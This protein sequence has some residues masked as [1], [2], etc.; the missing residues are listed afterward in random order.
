[1]NRSFILGLIVLALCA[2]STTQP[3]QPQNKDAHYYLQQG[4]IA[5]EKEH[6]PEAIEHW[7]KVRDSFTSPE[8]TALAELKIADA[9]FN[10]DQLIEAIAAY[11]DFLKQHPGHSQT[12]SIL[13][14]LGNA[15]YKQILDE[16]R[17]QTATRNALATFEQVQANYPESVDPAKLT[18]LILNCRDRLAANEKY[19]GQF[20]LKTKRYSAA[21][22]RLKK[23]S[24]DYPEY[25][26][27]DHVL[28]SLA[29]AQRLEGQ[30]EQA[31]ATLN[32]L[33][34]NT[35]D[36]ELRKSATKFRDKY[37]I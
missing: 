15:H 28:F 29:Q 6:Y 17:D 37:G 35:T 27:L 18:E 30:T 21:I 34:T 8:L 31:T 10:N 24:S 4:E 11:E 26:G 7:Q 19:I 3:K 5:F 13:F 25:T 16:D 22:S 23:I 33:E 2:C 14:R 20:Y 12:S 32:Q 36:A 9:Q 1:M